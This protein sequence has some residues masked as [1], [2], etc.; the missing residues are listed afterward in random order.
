MSSNGSTIRVDLMALSHSVTAHSTFSDHDFNE[1]MNKL[2]G[3]KNFFCIE[4]LC[5]VSY[6]YSCPYSCNE[7]FY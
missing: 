2:L 4:L 5:P 7:T 6:I 3:K 1:F